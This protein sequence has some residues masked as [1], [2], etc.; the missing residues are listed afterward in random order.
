MRQFW[1]L[2]FTV[3]LTPFPF[4]HQASTFASA[5]S[6]SGSQKVISIA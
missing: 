3:R 5:A 6:V 1:A 2:C 4:G